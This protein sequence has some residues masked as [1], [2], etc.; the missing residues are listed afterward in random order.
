MF[1]LL[2]KHG[3]ALCFL[4]LSG[5]FVILP[6]GCAQD[7]TVKQDM[8]PDRKESVKTDTVTSPPPMPPK[9]EKAAENDKIPPGADCDPAEKKAPLPDK[10][11]IAKER[12][13]PGQRIYMDMKG[14]DIAIILRTLSKIANQ[15]IMIG[16]NVTGK[17]TISI[18]NKPWDQVF[19]GLLRTYSLTYRWEGD[20]I[21]IMTLDDIN[22]ELK[23]LE[24]I[25]RKKAKERE[26]EDVAPLITRVINIEYADAGQFKN[27]FNRFLTGR[28]GEK[29]GAVMLDTHTNS[30]IVQASKE[31]IDKLEALAEKLDRPTSQI[32]IVAR[33]VEANTKT[34]RDLGV[35][36]GG[37][38]SSGDSD[39][40]FYAGPGIVTNSSDNKSGAGT[41]ASAIGEGIGLVQKF[42]P[43]PESGLLIGFLKHSLGNYALAVQLYALEE[44]G[45]LKIISSPS[46]STM[47]N[48]KAVIE[49]GREVPYQTVV[50]DEVNIEFKKAVLRLEVTPH[51][52]NDSQLKMEI[53]T[54]K[55]ELDFSNDKSVQGYPTIITKKAETTVLLN[56]GETTVIGGLSK[57]SDSGGET[58]VPILKDIPLIGHL[59]KR[60]IKSSQQ[61]EL[62][63][64]ITPYI[65]KKPIYGKSI[66]TRTD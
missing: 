3:Q 53:I 16:E 62:M 51:I 6:A 38:Y 41:A 32:R 52:I 30:L 14:V 23:W 15:S 31:D 20:I 35:E 44:Q 19:K 54:Y 46:I 61:E 58:G 50:N 27:I 43:T 56:D 21:R 8:V 47:D 22:A 18:K 66:K 11:E 48:R 29:R 13:L 25:Q 37:Y 5:W 2:K 60:D 64:F 28:H 36:W 33:I 65:L 4:F 42:P 45:K 59:F 1:A 26:I 57:N 40:G 12:K 9:M 39:K 7:K 49:S 10:K 24:I 55:D 63:I 17:A 34:A